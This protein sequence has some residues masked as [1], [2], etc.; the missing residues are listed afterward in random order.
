MS[1]NCTDYETIIWI[2]NNNESFY[3]EVERFSETKGF[4]LRNCIIRKN[5]RLLW[6][7]KKKKTA[8]NATST[9]NVPSTV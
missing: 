8:G 2:G 6:G 7:L 4:L 9:I 1:T 3:T 5:V